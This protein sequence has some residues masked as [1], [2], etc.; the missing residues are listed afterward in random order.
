M[1]DRFEN[2]VLFA[3]VTNTSN[4]L[5]GRPLDGSVFAKVFS[6]GLNV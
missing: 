2:N 3:G 1:S 5:Q 4:S 6:L